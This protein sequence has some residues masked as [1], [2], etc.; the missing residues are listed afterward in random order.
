MPPEEAYLPLL[1]PQGRETSGRNHA[2]A[3]ANG[4][5][6]SSSKLSSSGSPPHSPQ[7][8]EVLGGFAAKGATWYLGD[9][10]HCLYEELTERAYIH[11][12]NIHT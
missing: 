7:R 3:I 4:T 11:N 12:T 10:E 2:A 1:E 5:P 9:V 6:I 8:R